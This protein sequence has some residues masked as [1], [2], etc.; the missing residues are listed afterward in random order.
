MLLTAETQA[1]VR[2]TS[3]ERGLHAGKDV[4]PLVLVEGAVLGGGAFSRVSIV[5]GTTGV[6]V[7]TVSVC[8]RMLDG[9]MHSC[10]AIHPYSAQLLRAPSAPAPPSIPVKERQ[11]CTPCS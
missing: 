5:T 6:F 9:Y 11:K 10:L 4:A 2:G 3:D 7:S 8:I 1:G